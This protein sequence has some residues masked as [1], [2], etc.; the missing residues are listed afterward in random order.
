MDICGQPELA[1]KLSEVYA[2]QIDFH[3][4]VQKGDNFKVV[5]LEKTH[6]SGSKKVG[7]LLAAEYKSSRKTFNAVRFTNADGRDDFFDLEGQS[8][9]RAFLRSPFKYMPRISSRYSRRR[10]HPILKR[11]R[12]H[13]GVDYAAPTGTPVL[14]LGD[15]KVTSRRRNGGFGRHIQIKHNGLYTTGYGHLSRYARGLKVGDWV[16]Q[17]Q[18][19]GYVGS[20]GL[21]T[22]PHLDFRFYKSGKPVDPLKIDI[23][24]GDPLDKSLMVAFQARC[25]EV[26]KLINPNG[27]PGMLAA[28]GALTI[29][30]TAGSLF[31]PLLPGSE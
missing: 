24:A 25:E 12:P 5:Y 11:Y 15:G 30:F 3:S 14:A 13:L 17:G 21:A 16:K 29:E 18:V 23:P 4:E 8:L 20:T 19:I 1:L 7:D 22:G 26:H 6:P 10:F 9:R 31:S 28:N 27:G 2:W